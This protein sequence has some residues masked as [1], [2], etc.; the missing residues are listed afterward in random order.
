VRNLRNPT[1]QEPS[2]T[3]PIKFDPYKLVDRVR[4][5]ETPISSRLRELQTSAAGRAAQQAH[6]DTCN[7]WLIMQNENL[8]CPDCK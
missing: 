4:N 7:A 6:S 5:T 8:K 1:C 3:V 2:Q